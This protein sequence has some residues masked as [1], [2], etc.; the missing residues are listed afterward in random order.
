MDGPLCKDDFTTKVTFWD[1]RR[2]KKNTSYIFQAVSR[3][4]LAKT[5]VFKKVSACGHE[6]FLLSFIR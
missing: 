2:E 3:K 1:N 6:L 4:N 5:K